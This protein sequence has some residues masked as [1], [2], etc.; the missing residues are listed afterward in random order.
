MGKT[1]SLS[2]V[3][4][5]EDCGVILYDRKT[6]IEQKRVPFPKD[7]R[8]GKRYRM[9][10]LLEE[11][12]NG[13]DLAYQIYENEKKCP[14]PYG[15]GFF[16]D[17]KYGQEKAPEDV[18]TLFDLPKFDWKN[19]KRPRIQYYD[20]LIY[21]MHVRGFTK[22]FSSGVAH[23]G[24]FSAVTEKIPYLKSIGVTTLEFQPVYEFIER[25]VR[26]ETVGELSAKGDPTQTRLNYWGYTEGFYYAP[27]ADYAYGDAR[28]EFRE[29]IRSLHEAGME[30]VLQF[31]FPKEL[32]PMDIPAVL[33]FWVEEYQVDGFHLVGENLPAEMIA[34]DP[35][36]SDTKLWYYHLDGETIYGR[37]GVPAYK[38]LGLMRDDFLYEG[39]KFLKG[40]ENLVASMSQQIRALPA[41]AAKIN[42]L[43]TYWGFTMAD[44]VSYDYKHNEAN[45]EEN[46]D[47]TDYNC[48]WN[49]GEE[50]PSRKK[51]VRSLR[52][53]QL[54]NAY[55]MLLFAQGTPRIFMGDEFGNSQKGNNNPYCQDNEVTWLNWSK[56]NQNKELFEFFRRL[57]EIRKANP[58]LRPGTEAQMM[59][60]I[61]SG[62]PEL[63]FHGETAWRPQLESYSR[64]LGIL[65]CG[66]YEEADLGIHRDMAYP[67][68]EDA[69]K[70]VDKPLAEENTK[71]PE[72]GSV[73]EGVGLKKTETFR[74]EFM[75]LG[76]NMHWEPHKLGLPRLP[77]GKKWTLKFATSENGADAEPVQDSVMIAPKTIAFYVST[78]IA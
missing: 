32:N 7:G 1:Y 42:Y 60:S 75:Y 61:S 23:R 55:C 30:A 27:K 9:E 73:L 16:T 13:D 50:G 66:L 54:K 22:H 6:K 76:I 17:K 29:M 8:I 58:V 43:S 15:K 11:G 70:P 67:G 4:E 2:Y 38:N 69:K 20:S 12:Q 71:A 44:M 34:R 14:D 56:L 47:G 19:V 51:K 45:G 39:R 72:D 35:E 68:E 78:D 62:Y 18:Y 41:T 63:S 25:P 48:S 57:V 46:H 24:T 53:T 36:L 52:M 10:L 37:R 5:S 64:Q 31:Y 49:C 3:S 40:D 33:R 65:Y 28:T 77:K 74:T 21:C 59:D 26:K